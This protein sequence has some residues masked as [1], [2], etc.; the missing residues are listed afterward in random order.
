MRIRIGHKSKWYIQYLDIRG[1]DKKFFSI[2]MFNFFYYKYFCNE[3]F[4]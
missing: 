1:M 3:I 2:K 4:Y